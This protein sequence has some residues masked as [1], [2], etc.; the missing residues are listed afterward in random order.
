MDILNVVKVSVVSVRLLGGILVLLAWR[1]LGAFLA[2][3]AFSALVE[4]LV[5]AV[6]SRQVVPAMNWRP[7]FSLRRW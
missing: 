5:Y 7:G 4:V 3:T 6:V 2:W 1:D